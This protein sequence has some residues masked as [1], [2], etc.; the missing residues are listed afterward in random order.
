MPSRLDLFAPDAL[1]ALGQRL[2]SPTV[3]TDLLQVA[4]VPN[5]SFGNAILTVNV[6]STLTVSVFNSNDDE[7]VDRVVSHAAKADGPVSESR[8]LLVRRPGLAFVKY[9]A[10][11]SLKASQPGLALAALGFDLLAKADGGGEVILADYHRHD[12]ADTIQQAILADLRVMR[13][14]LRVED[15]LG[16]RENE[17]VAQQVVGKVSAS[18]KVSWADVFSGPVAPLTRFLRVGAPILINVDAGASVT[19]S[20]SFSDDFRLVFSRE[21]SDRWRV[22]L[23]KAD[24]RDAAVGVALKASASVA[25]PDALKAVLNAVVEGV[26]GKALKDVDALLAQASMQALSASQ[27]AVAE[28]LVDRLGLD[29]LRATLDDVR[30]RVEA[31]RARALGAIEEIVTAKVELGFAYQYRRILQHTTVLEATLTRS[32][33]Q[34]HHGELVRGSFGGVLGNAAGVAVTHFLYETSTT[35]LKAWGFSLRVG[36]WFD[37]GGTDKKQIHTVERRSASN[38]RQIA[39]LAERSYQEAGTK[40]PK[41]T[42]ELVAEMPAFASSPV[43]P[44]VSEFD[45]GLRFAWHEVRQSLNEGTLAQW[46]DLA[47]L[48]GVCPESS[49]EG[50][51]AVMRAS[52]GQ[53]CA[54]A[55]RLAVPPAAF[56]RMRPLVAAAAPANFAT[57]LGAAMPWL[58]DEPGRR[59]VATRRQLYGDLWKLHFSNP[60]SR[61]RDFGFVAHAR[62]SEQGYKSLAWREMRYVETPGAGGDATT[63]CGLIDLNGNTAQACQDFIA[64][65]Q[66]LSESILSSR[67]A[68]PK[69]IPGVFEQLEE[70]WKQSL[71]VRALGAYLAEVAGGC[72]VAQHLTRSFALTLSGPSSRT[73][74]V[75]S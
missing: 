35:V 75:G 38:L 18:V 51:S 14:S 19:M 45:F 32:A 53:P 47:V 60:A 7:D 22:A 37:I 21:A 20:V 8:P 71:H 54:C 59:S 61:G 28:F 66:V 74:V 24:T 69:V 63:F 26:L 29:P 44:L 13:S 33:L 11:A 57:F 65:M 31:I 27:R 39:Y 6:G 58:G 3:P 42:V 12:G 17:A 41:W 1:Q 70:L 49:L 64:G 55:V 34:R 40:K 2:D 9:R 23:E 73:I 36:S 56:L 15:V 67:Q 5:Q 48:W 43:G 4:L 46:L 52:L 62:L 50:V 30:A 10:T 16:L 25:D 68:G 72:G